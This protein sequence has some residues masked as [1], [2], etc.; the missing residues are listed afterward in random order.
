MGRAGATLGLAAVGAAALVAFCAV[1]TAAAAP[2]DAPDPTPLYRT[3]P[4]F[5]KART[6][7]LAGR[8]DEALALLE[9]W[10]ET[11]GAPPG[12]LVD[13]M[14]G[15][16]LEDAARPAEAL[17]RF[18]T[19]TGS[20]LDD[21]ARLR[22]GRLHLQTGDLAR[23]RAAFAGIS[24]A[25]RHWAGARLALAEALVQEGR[26][27]AAR[28][29][30]S[31]LMRD[32]LPAD[33][34]SGATL[35]LVRALSALGQGE[36][37]RTLAR[38]AWL[39]TAPGSTGTDLARELAA[40]GRP[41][42]ALDEVLRTLLKADPR[43]AARIARW[44]R[45]HRKDAD[46]RDPGLA[47]LAR[48]IA[49]QGDP[50]NRDAT[51][52]ALESAQRLAVDPTLGALAAYERGDALVNGGDDRAARLQFLAA[53]DRDPGG[54]LASDAAFSVARCA[55]RIGDPAGAVAILDRMSA[56]D[57]PLAPDVRVRWEAALA[58][59]LS[60]RTDPALAAL[61][62]ILTRLDRGEGL[63]YGSAERARYFRGVL[64]LSAGHRD[65]ALADL[66]RVA[67]NDPHTW[68]GVLARERLSEAGDTPPPPFRDPACQASRG[69]VW[70]WR[71]GYREEARAEMSARASA[72]LLDEASARVLAV[73]LADPSLGEAR[74]R[75]RDYLRGPRAEGDQFLVDAAYPQPFGDEVA[76]AT[77]ESEL[78][79]ALVYGVMRVESAFHPRARSP[80]GAVGLMQLL[81][82]SARRVA[83]SVLGDRKVAGGLWR[84][85]NNVRLGTAYLSTLSQHFRGHVPL[86]LAGYHAGPGAARRFHRT[87]GALP[88]DLFVEALPYAATVAYVK[89]VVAYA[90]G[91]RA[92][93]D[94]GT[95]GPLVVQPRPP[96]S[97][98]PFMEPRRPEPRVVVPASKAVARIP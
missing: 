41:P 43:D 66:R 32:D 3:D 76:T 39:E 62:R 20:P 9:A 50:R 86:V 68:F 2:C 60:G 71:L 24:P 34:R 83:L 96:T 91:Y 58:W 52:Q 87:L 10:R 8:T 26:A 6:A 7:A 22:E 57:P 79:P 40:Q 82:A 4:G 46:A 70:L 75:V 95:R 1:R 5:A 63:P 69:P 30:L 97:L 64:L 12:N 56:A 38:A 49:I 72:G 53:Y 93:L 17:R 35:A 44:A 84:P 45:T 73:L 98:G 28:V 78:D 94:D 74:A 65:E 88:T 51:L 42:T 67:R 23:A 31:D 85:A 18:T 37:S 21:D 27:G 29:V 90:A 16:W 61:N 19:V 33:Q 13:W 15:R 54:P 36:S 81:P 92:L 89:R 11:P 48:G 25:S 55:A 47:D 14:A 80:K 77:A 59:M